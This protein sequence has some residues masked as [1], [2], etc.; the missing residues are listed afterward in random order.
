MPLFPTRC[1]P[2]QPC[3]WT[4]SFR[5][6]LSRPPWR[7]AG[8]VVATQAAGTA[9]RLLAIFQ[10][11]QQQ[12][13]GLGH[14]TSSALRLMDH[15]QRHP[16]TTATAVAT[17]TGMSFHTAQ[18]MF[19]ALQPL[20]IVTEGTGRKYGRFNICTGYLDILNEETQA[21]F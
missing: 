10:G 21:P 11:H 16:V 7:L 1:R 13:R 3:S 14:L 18:K 5:T 4:T 8:I 2:I 6:S 15:L 17:G 12:V 9:Q 19:S 20:G